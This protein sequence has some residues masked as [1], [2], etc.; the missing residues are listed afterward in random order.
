MIKLSY[1]LS[2]F[3]IWEGGNAQLLSGIVV[4]NKLYSACKAIS[5][6]LAIN[7]NLLLLLGYVFFLFH[8][9]KHLYFSIA[10]HTTAVYDFMRERKLRKGGGC[11]IG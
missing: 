3:T 7:D 1:L 2:L 8:L 9:R 10:D 5:R 4:R 11:R 6:V